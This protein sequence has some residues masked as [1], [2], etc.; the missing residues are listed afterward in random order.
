MAVR[1]S[2]KI[3]VYIFNMYVYIDNDRKMGKYI[4]SNNHNQ[5]A[6]Y[7]AAC[8]SFFQM[9]QSNQIHYTYVYH[10]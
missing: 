9:F 6:R 4:G 1:Y 8:F 3:Y 2:L 10:W 5:H 7:I